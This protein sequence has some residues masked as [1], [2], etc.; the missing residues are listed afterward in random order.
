LNKRECICILQDSNFAVFDSTGKVIASTTTDFD[1]T[2]D[3]KTTNYINLYDSEK[4]NDGPFKVKL[5]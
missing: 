1:K 5:F 4:V 2:S 3:K